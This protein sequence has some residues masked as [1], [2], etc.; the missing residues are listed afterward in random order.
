MQEHFYQSK[1]VA[2]EQLKEL[3]KKNDFPALTRFSIMAVFTIIMWILVV[4]TWEASW[5]LFILAQFGFAVAGCSNFA[6]A[7]ETAHNTAFKSDGWNK[8]ASYFAGIGHYYPPAFFKEFHFT[9]HRYTHIPG[10]D[11]EISFAGKPVPSVITT[12]PSYIAWITGIPI[13]MYKVMTT[14]FGGIGMP[15]PIRKFLYPYIRPKVRLK[16]CIDSL[17]VVLVYAVIIYLAVSWYEGFWGIILGQFLSHSLLG[18]YLAPEHNGLP[19]EGDILNRT[20]SMNTLPLIRTIMWNM[21]YHAEHHAYPGVPFHKLPDL[22]KVIEGELVHKE[23]G[24]G[25]FHKSVLQERFGG[26]NN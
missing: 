10:K 17:F 1:I 15:E 6:C 20:R 22:H 8:F 9:H 7:H 24:Y 12:L 23:I 2:K 13:L 25:Q 5:P 26:G 3:V 19:H 14:I 4:L 21:P 18:S 16:L 11:P